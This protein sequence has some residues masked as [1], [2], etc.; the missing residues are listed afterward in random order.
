MVG[1]KR[2]I[3]ANAKGIRGF[4]MKKKIITLL[5]LLIVAFG[6]GV[7][8][9][10]VNATVVQEELQQNE[11]VTL[12]RFLLYEDTNTGKVLGR[13]DQTV[14]VNSIDSNATFKPFAPISPQLPNYKVDKIVGNVPVS[15]READNINHQAPTVYVYISKVKVVNN[16]G[17]KKNVH[18]EDSNGN[19]SSS[20]HTRNSGQSV[21]HR[22]VKHGKHSKKNKKDKI[23][24]T[25]SQ[26]DGVQS[27]KKQNKSN[28][29]FWLFVI[30]GTLLA[31]FCFVSAIRLITKNKKD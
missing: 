24:V 7:S 18:L 2:R 10:T 8:C 16:Y 19:D 23:R 12:V 13:Q 30:F 1:I 28:N 4:I 9:E 5:S 22:P 14:K 15:W 17:G 27:G 25:Y 21:S 20:N 31:V 29:A 11:S 26:E 3:K 6:F